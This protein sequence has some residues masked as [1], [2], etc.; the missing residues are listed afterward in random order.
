MQLFTIA[1]NS[2]VI[3]STYTFLGVPAAALPGLV[4]NVYILNINIVASSLLFFWDILLN[5]DRELKYVWKSEFS[6]ITVL[7]GTIRL[8]VTGV[9]IINFFYNVGMQ[10][11]TDSGCIANF[12]LNA[13]F[14]LAIATCVDMLFI[15]RVYALYGR[16]KVLLRFLCTMEV[17]AIVAVACLISLSFPKVT[18][19]A[20]PVFHELPIMICVTLITPNIETYV[21]LPIVFVQATTTFLALGKHIYLMRSGMEFSGTTSRIYHTFIRDGLWIFFVL[22]ACLLICTIGFRM[23][24]ILGEIALYWA[25][26]LAGI[27]ASHLIIN[28]R[29][30]SYKTGGK[31]VGMSSAYTEVKFATVERTA[32]SDLST[33]DTHENV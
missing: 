10:G 12:W 33:R 17:I 28:L 20:N 8:L 3:S 2:T 31:T 13:T 25:Y 5:L 9:T 29:S 24:S 27:T 16:N 18:I 1:M 22:F 6:Y 11:T 14:G 26:P 30:A 4:N 7:F 19:V 21:W 15:F 32:L 23:H